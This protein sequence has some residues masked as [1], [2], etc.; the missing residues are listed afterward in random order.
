MADR[1]VRRKA[2]IGTALSFSIVIGM[3]GLTP[4]GD[5][6]FL[7]YSGSSWA[8]G[9]GA[10]RHRYDPGA[11]IVLHQTRLGRRAGHLLFASGADPGCRPGAISRRPMSAGAVFSG[12]PSAGAA[13]A[14][15]RAWVPDGTEVPGA[16][17]LSDQEALSPP[18]GPKPR[19]GDELAR[20]VP[21]T[22]AASRSRSRSTLARRRR[23]RSPAVGNDNVRADPQ[24]HPNGRGGSD[25]LGKPSRGFAGGWSFSYLARSVAPLRH[26]HRLAPPRCPMA[27]A[28]CL[29]VSTLGLLAVLSAVRRAAVLRRRQLRIIGPS[30]L[31]IWPDA[32]AGQRHGRSVMGLA[33]LARSLAALG[34][35]LIVGMSNYVHR[36]LTL[37][38]IVPRCFISPSG[39]TAVAFW[40]WVRDQGRTFGRV[41]SRARRGSRERRPSGLSVAM[42]RQLSPASG[43]HR[44]AARAC[45]QQAAGS[46]G[47]AACNL[48]CYV[49]M[50]ALLLTGLAAG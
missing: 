27:L 26:D 40:R 32:P 13:D 21:A 2:F 42:R 14:A 7:Q 39:A 16:A 43:H 28:G 50:W 45:G 37:A 20:S 31:K 35:A 34:L 48:T 11:R 47:L 10:V 33:I 17:T 3:M 44:R 15:D 38:A 24:R 5:W 41:T 19:G 1:I 25:D 4:D 30:R 22:L 46:G 12:G 49:A 6:V 29:I 23:Q 18:T 8:S 9:I 36:R